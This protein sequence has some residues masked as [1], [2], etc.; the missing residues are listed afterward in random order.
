ML[1]SLHRSYIAKLCNWA[2]ETWQMQP[3]EWAH[4]N[5]WTGLFHKDFVKQQ[6]G[7]Q[8]YFFTE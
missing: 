4:L 5:N 6:N 2:I 7:L 1:H 3:Q 8:I